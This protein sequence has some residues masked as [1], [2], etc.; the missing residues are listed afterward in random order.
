MSR[1]VSH[2]FA[3]NITRIVRAYG[4]GYDTDGR[5]I[6]KYPDEGMREATNASP[7]EVDDYV[8][9]TLHASALHWSDPL[10]CVQCR[11]ETSPVVE[12]VKQCVTGSICDRHAHV[13]FT[14]DTNRS[15]GE[16]ERKG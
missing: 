11:E 4:N 6:S 15:Q 14:A 2:Q 10:G 9:Q 1:E 3:W 12:T 7:R 8:T 16:S 13:Q 5:T